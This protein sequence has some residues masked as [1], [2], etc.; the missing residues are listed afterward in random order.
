M[1]AHA[2]SSIPVCPQIVKRIF[3]N[4]AKNFVGFEL[5]EYE[6]NKEFLRRVK[7]VG[8]TLLNNEETKRMYLDLCDEMNEQIELINKTIAKHYNDFKKFNFIYL[9]I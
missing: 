8:K 3:K 7:R 9:K 1:F 5:D 6:Y 4:I 2:G